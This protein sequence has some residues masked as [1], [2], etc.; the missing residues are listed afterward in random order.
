MATKAL[1]AFPYGNRRFP[2]P[3]YW[4]P[5]DLDR[6]KSG[7]HDLV[8]AAAADFIASTPQ[9]LRA[10]D[11]EDAGLPKILAMGVDL[12][13]CFVLT[14]TA[15]QLPIADNL[16]V[17]GAVDSAKRTVRGIYEY[18]AYIWKMIMTA[19]THPPYTV[20]S[21]YMYVSRATGKPVPGFTP[22]TIEA[23]ERG[24]IIPIFD[25]AG[26]GLKPPLEVARE[27]WA[28]Y[29]PSSPDPRPWNSMIM[30][31]PT[32]S[33]EGSPDQALVTDVWQAI[34]YHA[35]VMQANPIVK[36]KGRLIDAENYGALE[37]AV[38]TNSP[39]SSFDMETFE[40]IMGAD[41]I[42]W[43]GAQARTHCSVDTATQVHRAL[44]KH[45]P[46]K[47][48]RFVIADDC[49]NNIPDVVDATGKVLVPFAAWAD[50]AY[51]EMAK[52]GVRILK[53][54]DPEFHAIMTGQVA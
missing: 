24:E 23:L 42:V 18:V 3:G 29:G 13:N 50:A 1:T 45:D 52:D 36:S 30:A 25:F 32:H 34:H 17:P 38:Q 7:R 51:A 11:I 4:N 14:P 43:I 48:K 47:L 35:L 39:A 20:H 33:Q 16:S 44:K 8:E 19:D 10:S 26:S 28:K 46:A 22:I 31:W 21:R 27:L 54:T 37:A 49:H 2:V 15:L 40:H 5:D 41:W 6:I 12:Q 9:L 53:S